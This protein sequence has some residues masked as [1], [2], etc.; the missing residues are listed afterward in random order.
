MFREIFQFEL[1]YRSKRAA[2][3][4]YFGIIFLISFLAVTTDG[5]KTG[6]AMGQIKQNAPYVLTMLSVVYSVFLCL[7][8]SAIMG[9]AVLRDFEHNMEAI[10][11]STPINKLSY[12][13]G[14]FWGSFVVLVFIGSGTWLA[15]LLGDLMW[16]RDQSQLLPFN[17]WNHFQPFLLFCVPN[18]FLGGCLPFMNGTLSRKPIAIYTQGIALLVLYVAGQTMLKNFDQK[19]IAALIDPFGLQAFIYETQYWTPAERNQFLVPFTGYVLYNRLIWMGV[20]FVALVITYLG[21]SFNVVRKSP[22]KSNA[23]GETFKRI[24]EN[25]VSIPAAQQLFNYRTE[26]KQV[27]HMAKLYFFS[28]V[29]EIPFMG[30][31][32][33]GLLLLI[34]KSINLGEMYGT[35]SYPTTYQVL[36]LVTGS[37]GL[38]FLIVIVFYSGELLWKEKSLKIDLIIDAMPVSSFNVLAAKFFGLV[39]IYVML[40]LLLMLCGMA[41]QVAYGYYRFEP[42]VYLRTLFTDTL[43]GL[44]LTTFLCVFIQVL[45]NN[46]FLGY[47]VCVAFLFLS[48]QIDKIGVEHGMFQFASGKLGTFSDMNVYGHFVYPF[49]WFK[50]YWFGFSLL[51]FAIAVIFCVR[52]SEEELNIRWKAGKQRLNRKLVAFI[53]CGTILFLSSGFYIYY[54]TNV[55]NRYRNTD[56]QNEMRADY[57]KKY[58]AF[59]TLLQPRIVETNVQVDIY[60]SERDFTAEGYYHLRNKSDQPIKDLHIQQS[61]DDHLIIDYVKFDEAVTLKQADDVYRYYIYELEEPLQPG[62]SARMDFKVSFITEGFKEKNSSTRVIYNGTFFNNATFFP[63]IGYNTHYELAEDDDRKEQDLEKKERMLERNDS[64]GKMMTLFGDDADH[65]RFEVT[66]STSADQLA[67]APGYLRKEWQE[68]DRRY[69][70]YKMDVPMAN[71]YSIVSARY[72]VKRDTWKNVNLEIYYHP[73]HEYNLDRMMQAMKDALEYYSVNFSDYQYSQMRIMEFPR[74]ESFA[75]SFAN[76]IP[77]SEG[78]GFITRI[79]DPGKDIDYPYYVTAHEVAHQ[80]WGH[81]VMPAGVKGSSMIS[82][83]MS[84]YSALMVMKHSFTPETME[85]YLKF[86]LDGYLKGR[87]SERKKEQ[88]LELVEGQGY[89]HYNK[90]S[91]VFFALQDYIGEDSVN[92]AFRRFNKAW[93]FK[94][95]PYPVSSDLLR[96]IREVTPDSLQYVIHDMFET[97]TLFENKTLE[98]DYVEKDTSLF[99]VT[100]IVS[101]EKMRADSLGTETPT[102]IGDWIDIGVYSETDGTEKLVYLLKHRFTKKENTVVIQVSQKPSR[103]GIDPL[104]K[105]IDR[106]SDDNTRTVRKKLE[107]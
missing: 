65:I 63:A 47:V 28:V 1:K 42:S 43:G 23:S 37:F 10:L 12:L 89:I 94:D 54:N 13:M 19:N 102:P 67:I 84:Q 45:V 55:I 73:G 39:A 44:I 7:V 40:L 3:F 93:R 5:V 46:K 21:F 64:S 95:G 61:T 8:S 50:T 90:A 2:T 68:N 20:G 81:Q 99:E 29:R 53:L 100:L 97:I 14:R 57:E 17:F 59:E 103:A 6:G 91:L 105:L 51:L 41:I 52:G 82:E 71:F 35:N 69:F 79:K 75:Q 106:H 80:W 58:K 60:P 48:S 9:V 66:L 15:F 62:D 26:L 87:A 27:I 11:F 76:T 32:I 92:A 98:A 30:I 31:V 86:E 74:Y 56:M 85:R 22:V 107:R 78:I 96:C 38:F 34:L 25:A 49:T 33:S 101:A 88:P 72:A 70:H 4:V 104:H 36:N 83:S 77:F 16:W 24:D 18:L